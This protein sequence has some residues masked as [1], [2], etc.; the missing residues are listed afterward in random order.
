M[1]KFCGICGQEIVPGEVFC[2]ICGAP[3]DPE[4]QSAQ[5]AQETI[6]QEPVY[7]QT[8]Q[9]PVYQQEYQPQAY[10]YQQ[11]YPQQTY[12]QQVYQ[13][14][15]YTQPQE[16]KETAPVVGVGTYF[17]LNILFA[18]PVIGFIMII[19]M[20][21]APSNKS[22]KNFARSYL[23]AIGIVIILLVILLILSLVFGGSMLYLF[24]GMI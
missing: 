10:Q 14:N 9:E 2:S 24:E 1:S 15:V 23:L 3:V 11:Q 16:E 17:G 5:P 4:N 12:P 19:I 22:V 7:E 18:L 21:F 6:Y 13:Q 20:S 8:Y